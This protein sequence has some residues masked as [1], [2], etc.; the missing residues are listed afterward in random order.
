MRPASCPLAAAAK[1]LALP[2]W[3]TAAG[4]IGAA[5]VAARK[6]DALVACDYGAL[7]SEAVLNAAPLALNIHPSLLPR[8]RGAAP[9]ARAVL[10]GDAETGATIMQM[11]AKLDSGDMLMQKKIPILPETTGGMLSETLA[12]LG[13]DMLLQTLRECPPPSPQDSRRATHAAKITAAD[14]L[15]DFSGDADFLARQVRAFAPSPGAFAFL[16]GGRV[17]IYAAAATAG[18]GAPGE[19]LAAGGGGIVVA[20][21]RG[22]LSISRLRRAGKG[23]LAAAEFARGFARFPDS[24]DLPARHN[25][26]R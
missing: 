20:C 2:L 22:A 3:E 10:A 26:P 16:A 1:E 18:R 24:F 13:A 11:N 6:P 7:L 21:G 9:I 25:L 15:L 19:V 23:V 4:E 14:R 12:E 8:W 17:N 5:D